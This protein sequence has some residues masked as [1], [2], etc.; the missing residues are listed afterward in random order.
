MLAGGRDLSGEV[1]CPQGGCPWAGTLSQSPKTS[2]SRL[3]RCQAPGISFALPSLRCA[4]PLCLVVRQL[5]QECS[6]GAGRGVPAGHR[7]SRPCQ[8]R[9]EKMSPHP[10]TMFLGCAGGV[11]VSHP[12]RG[13]HPR[14]CGSGLQCAPC[15]LPPDSQGPAL[16]S[17]HGAPWKNVGAPLAAPTTCSG[18]LPTQKTAPVSPKE[19]Q[20]RAGSS[21][22]PFLLR[23]RPPLPP[24]PAR[25][26]ISSADCQSDPGPQSEQGS[27]VCSRQR[28]LAT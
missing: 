26:Q 13:T 22:R 10:P 20:A 16:H 25:C 27:G 9:P 1:R 11:P 4:R 2:C 6:A 24:P 5:G 3:A 28:Q 18:D 19:T 14:E 7:P 21:L 8:K 15:T 23:L 17:L 12:S